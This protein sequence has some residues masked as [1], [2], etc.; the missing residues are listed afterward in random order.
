MRECG[1]FTC[2][3]A[4]RHN[5]KARCAGM[6]GVQRLQL[7]RQM[8]AIMPQP[9][10]VG[11]SMMIVNKI[12]TIVN[13]NA[14]ACAATRGEADATSVEGG[15]RRWAVVVRCCMSV[16]R[17]RDT[18]PDTTTRDASLGSYG[19]AMG[20]LTPLPEGMAD[21]RWWADW[22]A[23]GAWP[24][25]AVLTRR[26]TLHTVGHLIRLR[27]FAETVGNALI[28]HAT[29]TH[30]RLTLTPSPHRHQRHLPLLRAVWRRDTRL[31]VPH[32]RAALKPA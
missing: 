24:G 10:K 18:S 6:W 26:D 30:Q 29:H 2:T 9:L 32:L 8:G 15:G 3:H 19:R 14:I 12:C 5:A 21:A 16:G 27:V 1:G 25:A 23:Q 17:R 31:H 20:R 22:L 28:T 11:A 7:R 4:P 13:N